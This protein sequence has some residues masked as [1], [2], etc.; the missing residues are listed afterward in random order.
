MPTASEYAFKEK[1][2]KIIDPSTRQDHLLWDI[3]IWDTLY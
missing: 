3:S 2:Y 1:I